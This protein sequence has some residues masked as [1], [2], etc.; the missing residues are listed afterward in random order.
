MSRI[1]RSSLFS[2]VELAVAERGQAGDKNVVKFQVS[3]TVTRT[4]AN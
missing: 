3:C 2:S 1:E 4:R